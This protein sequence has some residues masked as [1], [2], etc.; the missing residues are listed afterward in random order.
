MRLQKY[1]SAAGLCSRRE[2]EKWI[3]AGRVSVNGTTASLGE[4]CEEG[5]I[6]CVD[7]KIV[8]IADERFYVLLNKPRGYVTTLSDEKGRPTVAELVK[9]V[10]VRL[11]PVGRLDY[12]SEGLLLMTD[13][14]EVAN[15]MMHPS[16]QVPKTYLVR[17]RG[18]AFSTACEKL[19]T[20]LTDKDGTHF[21]GA[22]ATLLRT[23]A[24]VAELSMTIR[25]GK[26]REIRRM[27]ALVGLEVLRLRRVKQGEIELGELPPGTWRYLTSE[28]VLFLHSVL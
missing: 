6:V 24:D 7:G 17:V 8:T 13:D 16:H 15:A 18:A 12:D 14:G 21:R 22:E 20:P 26:N 1:L 28:E 10:G 3:E 9:D 23:S 4:G 2:A 25:E 5:D 11:Y 19:R 27:C